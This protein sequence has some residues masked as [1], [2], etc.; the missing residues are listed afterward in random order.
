MKSVF[1]GALCL[2]VLFGA[3]L[4]F[5]G[6]CRHDYYPD[7]VRCKL[8][9]T[10]PGRYTTHEVEHKFSLKTEPKCTAF[11]DAKFLGMISYQKCTAYD[12]IPKTEFRFG[13]ASKISPNRAVRIRQKL[14]DRVFWVEIVDTFHDINLTL[15]SSEHIPYSGPYGGLGVFSWRP[16]G[17]LSTEFSDPHLQVHY[18][19]ECEQRFREEMTCI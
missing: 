17:E 5:S 12:Y 6:S 9:R 2:Q 14:R 15:F 8:T 3:E 18:K 11:E 1:F 4:G 13:P 16:T 19:I 7:H 10:F